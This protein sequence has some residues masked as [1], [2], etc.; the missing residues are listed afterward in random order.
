MKRVLWL[1]L[2]L[3]SCLPLGC[4]SATTALGLRLHPV[5]PP[6]PEVLAENQRLTEVARDHVH[7]FLINGADPGHFCNFRGQAEYVLALGYR[8]VYFGQMWDARRCQEQVL[9]LRREDPHCRVV[10]VGYSAG[11][12][13]SRD[14]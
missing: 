8:N 7:V 6:Q 10:L 5:P 1:V 4:A 14:L 2:A 12:Y 3:A 13:L 9:K 11:V